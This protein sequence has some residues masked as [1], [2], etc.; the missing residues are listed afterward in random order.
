MPFPKE[1]KDMEEYKESPNSRM[2]VEANLD[3]IPPTLGFN[4]QIPQME[5]VESPNS[6]TVVVIGLDEIPS[7]SI[8]KSLM[9]YSPTTEVSPFHV[10][11]I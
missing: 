7:A 6:H 8:V 5:N 1:A 11:F 2:V 10:I 9:P 3:D 4:S